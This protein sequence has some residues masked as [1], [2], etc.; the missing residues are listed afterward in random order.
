MNSNI[1]S[2]DDALDVVQTDLS[3]QASLEGLLGTEEFQSFAAMSVGTMTWSGALEWKIGAGAL[4][5]EIQGNIDIDALNAQVDGYTG[6]INT[7]YWGISWG[8]GSWH[9]QGQAWDQINS[10]LGTSIDNDTSFDFLPFLHYCDIN[11]TGSSIVSV[12]VLIAAPVS[13]GEDPSLEIAPVDGGA[14]EISGQIAYAEGF[15][16]VKISAGSLTIDRAFSVQGDFY[17]GKGARYNFGGEA[18][19]TGSLDP[20]MRKYVEKIS[21]CNGAASARSFNCQT[22]DHS[23]VY[24]DGGAVSVGTDG[25]MI[26]DSGSSLLVR[27]PSSISG[28]YIVGFNDNK[29]ILDALLTLEKDTN[30]FASCDIDLTT[31]GFTGA[32]QLVVC[33]DTFNGTTWSTSTLDIGGNVDIGNVAVGFNPLYTAGIG[34]KSVDFTGTSSPDANSG[35][36]IEVTSSF[37]LNG[38]I[39]IGGDSNGRGILDV[40]KEGVTINTGSVSACITLENRYGE[41]VLAPN[42]IVHPEISVKDGSLTLNAA[43]QLDTLSIAGGSVEEVPDSS[44]NSQAV[45]INK[46]VQTGGVAD[47]ANLQFTGEVTISG[48]TLEALEINSLGNIAVTGSGM[49]EVTSGDIATIDISTSRNNIIGS[50]FSILRLLSGNEGDTTVSSINNSEIIVASGQLDITADGGTGSSLVLSG[51]VVRIEDN[52]DLKQLCISGGDLQLQASL[53]ITEGLTTSEGQLGRLSFSGGGLIFECSGIFDIASHIVISSA[54]GSIALQARGSSL[55]IQG[56]SEIDGKFILSGTGAYIIG[57]DCSGGGDIILESGVSMLIGDGIS[58][59]PTVVLEGGNT[60]DLMGPDASL[61]NIDISGENNKITFS[62][63]VPNRSHVCLDVTITNFGSGVLIDFPDISSSQ[64]E[65]IKAVFHDGRIVVSW[66]NVS[67]GNIGTIEIM[68]VSGPSLKNGETLRVSN[69]GSGGIE[70]ETCFLTGTLIDTVRGWLP[71]E[72]LR[73]GD[74]VRTYKNS[75]TSVSR[76]NWIGHGHSR[77]RP[78]L[79]KDLSGMPV[80]VRRNAFGADRPF[81]DLFVTAEHCVFVEGRLIPVRMLVNNITISYCDE[82]TDYRYYHF[83]TSEHEVISANGL[84]TETYLD[85]GNR[86]MF[87]SWEGTAS[88]DGVSPIQLCDDRVVVEKIYRTIFP[89][90]VVGSKEWTLT[91]DFLHL[92]LSTGREVSAKKI[93][94]NMMVFDIPGVEIQVSLI[95]HAARPCDCVAPFVDDRR[96]LGAL[97]GRIVVSDGSLSCP[98]DRHFR[99][100][101]R[102]W[103]CLEQGPY[104]WTNGNASLPLDVPFEKSKPCEIIIEVL[105]GS[106]PC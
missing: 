38:N 49:I 106:P 82:I 27:Q 59:A 4:T 33:G 100:N 68:S 58:I 19:D 17:I 7:M 61:S 29:I 69:D 15:I 88:C 53:T 80:V 1:R 42:S 57:A 73:V 48:G 89:K 75:A 70:V 91:N 79:P 24:L 21:Y 16:N 43:D 90:F 60:L 81:K 44:G 85:T 99:D 87:D 6:G 40:S 41:I 71:V 63:V 9:A 26:L 54:G 66:K 94:G 37:T 64:Y 30:V 62:G 103:H 72:D 78:G 51:G 96:M 65:I 52:A 93:D 105:S 28:N 74:F 95:S 34:G 3:K 92:R 55:N 25:M 56:T 86:G 45:I 18:A 5:V 67:D 22:L 39:Q 46:Y 50:S 84:Y 32:G 13:P 31:A 10:T 77:F 101:L 14:V 76:I 47:I 2:D 12:P 35:G 11:F 23:T 97:I 83:Q 102:G 36:A 8:F 20:W 98:V 104:R